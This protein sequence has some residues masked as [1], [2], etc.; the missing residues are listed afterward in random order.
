ML[1]KHHRRHKV[2]PS[3]ENHSVSVPLV[4][5]L[6]HLLEFLKDHHHSSLLLARRGAPSQE[7]SF[8]DRCH[9]EKSMN[10]SSLLGPVPIPV[11]RHTTLFL[12]GVHVRRYKISNQKK[13][14]FCPAFY[15][16][17]FI[18]VFWRKGFLVSG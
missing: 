9:P 2:A 16:P 12:P 11:T 4:P 15:N 3:T 8:H 7:A 13:K 10:K 5:R 1:Q 14:F 18:K 6:K 17:I